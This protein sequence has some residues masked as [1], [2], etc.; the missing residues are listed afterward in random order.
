MNPKI[1]SSY[2]F[3]KKMNRDR[4]YIF[5][6]IEILKMQNYDYVI[7]LHS[8]FL[9]QYMGKKISKESN[10]MYLKYSKRK[11]WKSESPYYDE[12]KICANFLTLNGRVKD[13]CP[14]LIILKFLALFWIKSFWL[15]P[16]KKQCLLQ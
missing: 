5:S 7:D 12:F 14:Y 16:N 3:D 13:I 2:H 6:V 4:K 8:K 11:W 15:H 10:A 1:L 9:S